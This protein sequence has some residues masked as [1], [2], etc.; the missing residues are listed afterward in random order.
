MGFAVGPCQRNHNFHSIS[1]AVTQKQSNHRA[2]EIKTS[3]CV[4]YS[5]N[6]ISFQYNFFSSSNVIEVNSVTP[7]IQFVSAASESEQ[8]NMHEN[9]KAP[10]HNTHTMAFM[11]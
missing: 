1:L 3:N 8:L 10:R 11:I 5:V 9:E 6:A 7:V 4:I 2:S